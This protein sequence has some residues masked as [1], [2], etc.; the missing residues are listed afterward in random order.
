MERGARERES[1]A[2]ETDAAVMVGIH[3]IRPDQ[4]QKGRVSNG[5]WKD[6]CMPRRFNPSGSDL[7][8]DTTMNC[9]SPYFAY[10]VVVGGSSI[11]SLCCLSLSLLM[12]SKNL[13]LSLSLLSTIHDAY[14][15]SS[16][17]GVSTYLFFQ[18]NDCW[19]TA[20]HDSRCRGSRRCG[21]Y[22][23]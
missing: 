20:D 9:T 5:C 12:D 22:G 17:R 11:K 1:R 18:S 6:G 4:N 23:N 14:H 3:F 21:H 7:T 13:T 16:G 15:V 8:I 2:R 10:L 19:R